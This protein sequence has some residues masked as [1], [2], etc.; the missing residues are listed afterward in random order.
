MSQSGDATA[1]AVFEM[2]KLKEYS[3]AQLKQFLKDLDCPTESST[4]EGELQ[5]AQRAGV[6]IKKAGGHTEEENVGGEV[7][8]IHSGVVEV[9][10]TPGG[11]VPRRDS[12]VSPKGLTPEELQDRRADRARR[13]KKLEERRRDLEI[14]KMIYAYELKLKELEVMRAESSWNGGSNNCISSDAAEVHMPR[15]VVSY[16]KEG[17]NTRQEVQGYEVAPVMH[18]VPEVDWGTGM[19]S[20]IP[21]GGR[22]TLLTLVESDRERGSPQVEVLVMECENIPEECGLSVRDSQVLSHQSQEGDVGC[23]VKAESLDGWVKGTLVNSCEGLSDEIAGEHMSSPYFPELCQHQVECEFSDPRELTMEA[24]FWVSTRESEE[25]FGGAP[26]RSGLG[27]SQPGEVGKDCS[28]P[29]R[30]QC[31]GMGEGPHVQSQRRGNG[32]GLRPKVPEIRSQVLEGSLREPQEGSLACTIGPSVEGDPTVSGELGGAAVASVPPVLV[33]GST[34]PSEGL[35]K[36]RQRVERGLRT[37]VE[38]LE[39][40]GSALRAEPPMNDLGET[41]SGLGGIQTLSDGQRSGDLRQPDS[42]V[43]LR[44]S[45]SLEGGKCAPLEVLVCQAMVQPQGGDSGL[46]DQVQGVNSDLMGGKCAPKEVLVCQAMVQPQGGDSG[47]ND[48]VQGVNSDLMGGKCAPKEVLVCQAVVQPQGGDPGLDDQVQRVNSDLVGGRYAPQEVLGCQAVIQSVDTDPGLGGQVKGVPPDLEE[49]ATANS[50]PTML[51]S[52]G[53]T[54]SWVVQDPRRE[55]RG[56]EASPLALVQPEGTDPRLEDQLQVNIPALMEELC[57]TA[58]TSTLTVFDSGGAASAGRVQ[59]PR[60]EDQG[61]V[62]I[63]DLV[64]ERVVKGCQAPGATTPHSPQSPWL[65]RPEVGLSSLTVV[66]GHCGLLSWWTELPL[67]GGGRES[68]PGGGVGNT[69][70]LALVVLS[71]HCNASV[72]KVKLGVAQM[73]S[74]DVE[75]GSPWV[76]LVGPESMDRGIQL[77]SGRRRTGTC[78]CCCGPGS[79]FYRPN[80]GSTSRY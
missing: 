52:G 12:R 24:D 61:Q 21:T 59:S 13:F 22:D 57:R 80:Q 43:A 66:W 34:T 48:Q 32:D 76:S 72:S 31:S 25:A 69:T 79:L 40:Q 28:V 60:G 36:S 51:S 14:K 4:R 71:A 44:D 73:V 55:G 5:Q 63:P 20:H 27:S 58:S 39:G 50:A 3:V 53:A 18:R 16:L 29:G 78:P 56:R 38:N 35:Q 19:G 1:G 37:P 41:I 9:P 64:E 75:K 77:E 46:N 74:V 62:N 2:E 33:S 42:C 70:V 54:P 45:V 8:R 26:E 17:V 65:E 30:S 6:T 49:G 47:L 7:Q 11:R 68:H 67:G 23:F 15:E 10:V